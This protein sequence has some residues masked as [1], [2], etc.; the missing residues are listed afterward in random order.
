[1]QI[2]SAETCDYDILSLGEILLR[3]DTG[4]GR[5]RTLPVGLERRTCRGFQGAGRSDT[6]FDGDR[7]AFIGDLEQSLYASKIVSYA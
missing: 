5:V 1:M 3:L 6:A 4:E 7:E 2:K